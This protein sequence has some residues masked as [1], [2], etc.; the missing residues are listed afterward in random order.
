MIM[1]DP[2]GLGI[3]LEHPSKIQQNVAKSAALLRK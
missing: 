2:K 1:V 3:A